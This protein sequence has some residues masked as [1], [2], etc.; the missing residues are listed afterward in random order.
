MIE[1]RE[2]KGVEATAAV[3]DRFLEAAR[4]RPELFGVFTTFSAKV[5]QLRFDIDR[6]KARRLDVPVSDVFSVLQTNLGAYYINDFN[7]FGKTWK[8]MIQAESRDRHQPDDIAR[9]YVLNRQGDKVPLSSLGEVKYALG[10]IDVP[11]Y[12]MYTAARIT[13]QPAQGF[14]SGQAI[15]AMHAV[16]AEVLPEGYDYEWTGTTYQEQKTGNTATYIFALSIICVFLFMSALYES[17]I[18]P[19]VII[20]TV[21]LATF[22]A[23][24]GLWLYD[25][26]LDVFGQIGLVMLI[27]LETKNAILIVEFGVEL[28]EKHGMSI[29][30]SAKEASRQR[31]R[32]ILMTSFAFVFG[33]LPMAQATGAGAY[34]RNSLGIVIAFGIAVSTVLGR[35]VIPI[36][37]VLGERLRGSS[38]HPAGTGLA[39][40]TDDN[41]HTPVAIPDGTAAAELGAVGSS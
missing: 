36:Y 12:N 16:A 30:D 31:L 7:L 29:V 18:R 23:M 17:W 34:S 5:P 3:V 2:G 39:T 8:V 10:P 21:P 24:I 6:L 9:L 19:L 33:V 22:G 14:S 11:H 32:P 37:Y 41:G 13:G 1:D 26:P 38:P 40:P 35:F 27:G 15:E 25:M 20:L 28:I 4:N